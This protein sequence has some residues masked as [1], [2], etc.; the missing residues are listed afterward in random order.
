MARAP[1]RPL[2]LHPAHCRCDKC[3]GSA[4]ADRLDRL[5]VQLVR[6]TAFAS[7][8]L[9]GLALLFAVGPLFGGITLARFI[10]L[11]EGH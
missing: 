9:L 10:L 2:P 8:L 11:L 5:A 4:P 3:R 7:G 6:L 1:A